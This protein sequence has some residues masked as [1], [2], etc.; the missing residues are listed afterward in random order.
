VAVTWEKAVDWLKQLQALLSGALPFLSAK[1]SLY[2]FQ[3]VVEDLWPIT[4]V[5][6]L[7]ASAMIFNMVEP[8]PHSLRREKME[9]V[10]WILGVVGL[11]MALVSLLIM[12]C[13]RA[14]KISFHDPETQYLAGEFMFV[15]EFFSIGLA[16]GFVLAVISRRFLTAS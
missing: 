12:L 1:V 2:P 9:S 16:L 7:I 10:G 13:L 15:S 6:A 5:L 14:D 11:F 3:N 4:S 8:Q